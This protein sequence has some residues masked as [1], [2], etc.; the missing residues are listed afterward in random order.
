MLH[1]SGACTL[2]PQGFGASGMTGRGID[3]ALRKIT[4]RPQRAFQ[5]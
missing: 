2:M 3:P 4:T 5:R 1:H